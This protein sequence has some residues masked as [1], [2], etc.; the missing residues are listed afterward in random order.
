M[1]KITIRDNE[2]GI[3]LVLSLILVMTMSVMAASLMFLSQTETY[4]SLNYRL[5]SQARYGAESG[6]HKT[7]N[8][9]LNTYVAPDTAGADPL[10]AYDMTKSPVQF[11]GA[12]VVL[13]GDSNVASNYP[14]A[15]VQTAFNA[16]AQGSLA[17]GTGSVG[18]KAYATMMS[19]QQINGSQT[20]ITWQITA[21]GTI[22]AG[23]TATAEVTSMLE[24][25]LTPQAN[26]VYAAFAQAST[27]GALTVGSSS[28]DSYDSTAALVSGKPV[29]AH[30]NG[31][32][33]TNGNLNE[34]NSATVWGSLSTPRVGVGA[35][36]AGNVD[37]LSSS[38]GATI[39]A[40][41]IHLS[42]NVIPATPA[43][44]AMPAA[45]VS[46][47]FTDVSACPAGFGAACHG[48][49]GNHTIDPGS[50]NTKLTTTDTAKIHLTAGVYNFNAIEID[51][52]SQLILDSGPVTINIIGKNADGSTMVQPFWLNSS[53]SVAPPASAPFDAL[54]FTLN[55]AGTGLIR[56][57]NAATDVGQINA[58]NAA[59]N[60]NSSDFY[61][62]VVGNTVTLGNA[63]KLH[64]DRHLASA[65]PITFQVGNDM[66]TSF[67]WK[68]Y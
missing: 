24:K 43:V 20:I 21:N 65:A 25:Q 9:L 19:M 66:L 2:R 15:A 14:V 4:A 61:G 67:S 57:D 7:A 64:F 31:N 46:A 26:A 36:S 30:N 33:G 35:C 8:Y 11:N 44:P 17:A 51:N 16:A 50:Y 63:A 56:F 45:F 40:G 29:T 1:P 13:S 68:K 60:I 54:Q 10:A 38:G 47:S 58:P 6:V 37:A 59:V 32:L 34:N 55:Y 28:V 41:I 23:R 48:P 49:V 18:Y 12:P 3:A 5:M 22:S 39:S 52:D 62:S 42:Q 27:C 53:K